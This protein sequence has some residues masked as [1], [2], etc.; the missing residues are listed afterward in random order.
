MLDLFTPIIPLE[1]QHPNFRSMSHPSFGDAEKQVLQDWARNFVDR[2]GKLVKEF[3][4][5]FNSTFW[6]LYLHSAFRDLGFFIN[7]AHARP[8]FLLSGPAEAV[9][10]ATIAAH[11]DGHIP[12]WEREFTRRALEEADPAAIVELASIRLANAINVKQKK[13][14]TEYSRLPHVPGKPFII[15]AAPFEQPFFFF[16]SDNAIRRVLYGYDQPLWIDRPSG[17]RIV[18]G[19]SLVDKVRKGTETDIELGIFTRPGLEHVSAVIFSASATMGKVRALAKG[20]HPLVFFTAL[21][22]AADAQHHRVI[23]AQRPA[24]HETV[25]DGLHVL[26]NPF[27]AHPIDPE[28]FDRPDVAI[29]TFDPDS[30]EYRIRSP[31]GFLFYRDVK[32]ILLTGD[33]RP[34][35]VGKKGKEKFREFEPAPWPEGELV[36]VGG[37]IWPAADNFMAHY[38][39]WTIVIYRDTIDND[40]GGQGVN[41]FCKELASFRRLNGD[42][43]VLSVIQEDFFASKEEALTHLKALVDAVEDENSTKVS[44]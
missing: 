22:Y 17:E 5:T 33:P 43:D 14:V 11:P 19:E 6:E 18:I 8:D 12:E 3:Q 10:E 40:W 41:G 36:Q 30:G 26:L 32:T 37:H 20:G 34:M 9:A 24:Y 38:R 25:L 1:K 31:D 21:R 16:Q 23:Q 4:S 35:D 44:P 27:A 2:D 28:V 13:Y 15:C 7:F 39:G 29:H 42:E